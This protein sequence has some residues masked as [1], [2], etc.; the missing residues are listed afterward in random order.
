VNEL[1]DE[2]EVEPAQERVV[3]RVAPRVAAIRVPRVLGAP[4]A[5]RAPSPVAS[6]SSDSD[7]PDVYSPIKR[8]I[9]IPAPRTRGGAIV[10]RILA[11]AV[12]SYGTHAAMRRPTLRN[13]YG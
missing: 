1:E 6:D 9:R 8:N 13:D 5:P 3:R 11:G 7:D 2:P 10:D 12:T 4:R